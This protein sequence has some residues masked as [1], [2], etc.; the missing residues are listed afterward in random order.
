MKINYNYVINNKSFEYNEETND[1][2]FYYLDY[3]LAFAPVYYMYLFRN[4]TKYNQVISYYTSLTLRT[5]VLLH[6]ILYIDAFHE[7]IKQNKDKKINL[8]TIKDINDIKD[9]CIYLMSNTLNENDQSPR[10]SFTEIEELLNRIFPIDNRFGNLIRRYYYDGYIKSKYI[11]QLLKLLDPDLYFCLNRIKQ[12]T[13]SSFYQIISEVFS[14]NDTIYQTF[15]FNLNELLHHYI[16]VLSLPMRTTKTY[17][18]ILLNLTKKPLKYNS[19]TKNNFKCFAIAIKPF[20]KKQFSFS[21]IKDNPNHT[22][23]A[24]LQDLA[25]KIISNSFSD[26]AEWCD[27]S[28]E[29]LNYVYKDDCVDENNCRFLDDDKLE[30]FK[31][32]TDDKSKNFYSCC[33]RKILAHNNKLKRF[34]I[35]ISASPCYRCQKPLYLSKISKIIALT[36]YKPG[37]LQEIIN[38]NYKPST[39]KIIF[40]GKHYHNIRIGK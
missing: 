17:I 10:I 7:K 9:Y 24:K 15:L 13:S 14:F 32:E 1:A 5:N 11:K 22:D 25:N 40:D 30:K 33:E 23:Y 39:Y 2:E 16:S 21:G 37:F 38:D 19:K 36:D 8:E 26:N 18:N 20:Y 35:F 4:K 3:L 6:D 29:T 27:L 34:N 12:I 31:T 28:D